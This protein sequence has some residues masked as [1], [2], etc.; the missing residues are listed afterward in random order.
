MTTQTATG[1]NSSVADVSSPERYTRYAAYVGRVGA[2]AVALGIGAA[3]ATGHGMGVGVAHADDPAPDTSQDDGDSPDGDNDDADTTPTPATVET[4]AAGGSA[5]PKSPLSRITDIPKMIF[6]ATGGAQTSSA[7]KPQPRLPRL[8]TVL[9]DV[10]TAVKD[11]ATAVKDAVPNTSVQ[12]PDSAPQGASTADSRGFTPAAKAPAGANSP[13]IASV[14]AQVVDQFRSSLTPPAGPSQVTRKPLAHV[15]G[16]ENAD[17]TGGQSFAGQQHVAQAAVTEDQGPLGSLAVLH[18]N[19]LSVVN[20]VLAVAVAPFLGPNPAAP[21]DPPLLLGVL[22]WARREIQRTFFNSRPDAVADSFTTSEDTPKTLNVLANDTDCDGDTVSVKSVTQPAHGDV[23]INGDGTLTYTPDPDY[24]GADSFSY[25]VIDQSSDFHLHGLRGLAAVVFCGDAG[26]T[27]TATVNI[28][29][30]PPPN[31]GPPV[32]GNDSGSVNEGDSTTID[33]LANDHDPDG[34]ATI[35]PATVAILTGPANGSTSINPTT[36]AITYVSNGTETT[37]DS[38]TYQV[39]DNSGAVSNTATV[40]IAITPVNDGPPVA[41]NDSGS[42]NEGDSTTIDVLANDHDPDGDA[43]INPATVAILTGP[44]NGS[45]SINPTTGAITYVSNGTETTSDSFTY[46]VKDNSGAVSNTATVNIAITPVNDAPSVTTNTSTDPGTGKVTITVVVT[47]PDVGDTRSITLSPPANGSLGP[48]SGPTYDPVAQTYTYTTVYT[49]DP[50]ARVNAYASPADP[51]LDSV[52]VTVSDGVGPNVVTAVSVPISP[53]AAAN[54]GTIATGG[55]PAG[56]AISPD[57]TRAYVANLTTSSVTVIDVDPNSATYN[58]VVDTNTT[59]TGVQNIQVGNSPVGV[60]ITPDGKRLYVTN[61]GSNSV[62]VI[63]IAP[64][65][66]NRYK[67]I[68]TDGVAANGITNIP[69]GNSPKEIAI[70]PDG[71]RAYVAN[72]G[73]STVTVIDIDPTSANYNKVIDADSSTPAVDA[74]P[75]GSGPY[76]VSVTP[77]GQQLYV[78]NIT[79]TSV[80]VVDVEAGSPTRYQVVDANGAAAGKDIALATSANPNGVA[81]S[82]DGTRAYVTNTNL[83]SVTVIDIAPG[84]P[85]RYQ[86]IDTNPATPAVDNIPVGDAP[87]GIKISADGTRAYLVNSLGNTMSVVDI[88]P[89]SPTRYQVID[90]NPTTAAIDSV[91]GVANPLALA[92]TPDGTRAYVSNTS[93]GTVTV[94]YLAATDDGFAVTTPVSYV[95]NGPWAPLANGN[96]IYVANNFDNSVTVIDTTTNTVVDTD[97]TTPG[98]QNMSVG[99]DPYALAA[100]DNRLYVANLAGNSVTVIDT[101]TN[102]VIH[103]ITTGV[104]GPSGL[105]VSGNRLYISNFY[106]G[107][108]TVINTDDYSKIDAD[109]GVPGVQ[110]LGL[111]TGTH[112]PYDSVVIG[113]RLYVA[114]DNV[115]NSVIVIDTDTDAVVQSIPVDDGPFQLLTKGNLLYVSHYTAGKVTVINTD[116]NTVAATISTG[117]SAGWMATQGN[118][119]YVGNPYSNTV[120]VVDTDSNT[121]VDTDGSLPGIQPLT[122]DTEPW[123]VAVV[124]HT[125]YV[126]NRASDSVTVIDLDAV[127]VV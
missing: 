52:T 97:A 90:T 4:T 14:P 107:D 53:L 120:T 117:S 13:T 119:L 112:S 77:N 47:D 76:A 126:F 11:V 123:G 61:A 64:G 26:H 118:R 41:G 59:V 70:S 122:V 7:T 23:V 15:L 86:I 79:S 19:H 115:A 67:A 49:P 95:G 5:K 55:Y 6:N 84:S 101:N 106:G 33:V 38:F 87:V 29:V 30:T 32:A 21:Q 35:N 39:K 74:I 36:G 65:S 82:P 116:T 73:S 83:D 109:G 46:Q 108:V 34:D 63:D 105:S 72:A 3:I 18:G 91:T 103:T 124:G 125:L 16:A 110:S 111:G 50:Q 2:L 20:T 45:T 37:S 99:G 100:S 89:G 80:T 27:D 44:A 24:N 113:N 48:I 22:A 43:T 92:L 68:D 31:A 127:S 12:A 81:F 56:I 102:T 62:S 28:T 40:N 66:P 93:N 25:S 75:V 78:T 71:T 9:D 10:A 1:I 57:G 8:S 69:V 121:V 88:A 17:A 96:R 94:I 104:N 58:Q 85:T 60:A 98:I 114:D 42:V 54:G 51:D